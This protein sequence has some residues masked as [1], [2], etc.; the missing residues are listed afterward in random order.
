MALLRGNTQLL[1]GS[2]SWEKLEVDFLDGVDLNLTNSNNNATITGL[3]DGINAR[4]AVNYQQLMNLING[5]SWK[6]SVRLFSDV[7]INPSGTATIDNI[8]VAD[9]DRVAIFEQSTITLDGVYIVNTSGAWARTADFASGEGV[10][11]YSFMVEEG[12]DYADSQWTVTNNSGTDVIGVDDITLIQTGGSGSIVAGDGLTMTGNVIDAVAADLSLLIN[13][14]DMQVNIGTTNGTSLE[15]SATGLEL[16]SLVT[17]DRSFSGGSFTINSGSNPITLNANST[18]TGAISIG[19]HLHTSSVY[20]AS[21]NT[22]NV[23]ADGKADIT[24]IADTV[25]IFSM[26][27]DILNEAGAGILFKDIEVASASNLTSIPFAVTKTAGSAGDIIDDFRTAF[28][29]EQAIINAIVKNHDDVVSAGLTLNESYQLGTG[30]TSVPIEEVIHMDSGDIKF[31]IEDSGGYPIGSVS[32]VG[33]MGDIFRATGSSVDSFLEINTDHDG[34]GTGVGFKVTDSTLSGT[35]GGITLE[36]DTAGT[37]LGGTIRIKTSDSAGTQAGDIFINSGDA[38][39]MS[40]AGTFAVMSTGNAMIAS[41]A[42]KTTVVAAGVIEFGDEEIQASSA[43]TPVPLTL[44]TTIDYGGG[45][46]V[47]EIVN[48]FRNRFADDAIINALVELDEA[49]SNSSSTLDEAYEG[50]AG[51]IVAPADQTITMDSGSVLWDLQNTS[52]LNAVAFKIVDGSTQ[53]SFNAVG[54]SDA[55]GTFSTSGVYIKGT[56]VTTSVSA[57]DVVIETVAGNLGVTGG[58]VELKTSSYSSAIP[59]NVLLT[60]GG[61]TTSSSTGDFTL[62][63]NSASISGNWGLTLSGGGGNVVINTGSGLINFHDSEID[64]TSITSIPLSITTTIDHGSGVSTG[65]IITDF[66]AAFTDVAIIN[67]IMENKDAIDASSSTLDEAYEGGA[68]SPAIPVPQTITI[69]S[70]DLTWDLDASATPAGYQRFIISGAT[71]GSFINFVE[72]HANL[73]NTIEIRSSATGTSTGGGVHISSVANGSGTGGDIVLRTTKGGTATAGDIVLE[74]QEALLFQDSEVV[75]ASSSTIPFAITNTVGANTDPGD[76]IDEFKSAFT[77]DAIINAIVENHRAIASASSTLDEA[78]EAG[79]GTTGSHID[80]I[81]TVDSGAVTWDLRSATADNDIRFIRNGITNPI[82]EINAD[83]GYVGLG[84]LGTPG[85]QLHVHGLTDS[86]YEGIGATRSTNTANSGGL[87]GVGRLRGS[88]F[89]A[90]V[91]VLSGDTLGTFTWNGQLTTTPGQFDAGAGFT[92]ITTENWDLTHHGTKLNLMSTLTGTA[93]RV[94][95]FTVEG[96]G[97]LTVGDTA[98]YEALVTDDD[99]IPNKKYVDDTITGGMTK[100]DQSASINV[101]NQTATLSTA[102]TTGVTQL[103]VYL[104]GNRLVPTSEFTITNAVT[105]EITLTASQTLT[106]GDVVIFDYVDA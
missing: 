76:I 97:S 27:D 89:F 88:S 17:G 77:D 19:D 61:A 96:D 43:S 36:T 98:N 67:A 79:A 28:P 105:G 31:N 80:H 5:R 35:G 84:T 51:N 104:N 68:G 41:T 93:T 94:N 49:V 83:N 33:G 99:D 42:G 11:S 92:A 82:L 54:Y 48:E 53:S 16:A 64:N 58:D 25:K 37:G 91:A 30:T 18:D 22:F 101:G 59:G 71:T 7:N 55:A 1:D 57:L 40:N 106:S 50:G 2:L 45:T 34:G 39:T 14:D 86:V 46:A 47:G 20:I 24:S 26:A 56:T 13:S 65:D 60:S 75:A 90:P 63:S 62:T 29:T 87:I 12:D 85:T 52:D 72:N 15:V 100:W 38:I 44:K 74:S 103:R 8:A 10:A 69:D 73:N 78:Y 66:D 23:L 102:P 4:D 6:Q 70:G 95:V 32:I 9:G 21:H 3:K 81:V